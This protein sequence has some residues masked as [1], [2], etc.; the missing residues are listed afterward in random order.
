M[1]KHVFEVEVEVLEPKV[2]PSGVWNPIDEP[3]KND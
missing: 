1:V 2:A 3:V